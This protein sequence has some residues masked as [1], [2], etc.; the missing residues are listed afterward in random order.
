MSQ[1]RT[2]QVSLPY[3]QYG[4][5]FFQAT[6]GAIVTLELHLGDAPP[7][8]EGGAMQQV[9]ILG[10]RA[11]LRA[12]G[13]AIFAV[14]EATDPDHHIHIEEDADGQV[15]HCKEKLTLTIGLTPDPGK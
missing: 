1:D 11:G 7:G 2:I 14:A 13:A 9:L 5:P 12:L 3:S 6:E 15:H 10:N 8:I 4:C